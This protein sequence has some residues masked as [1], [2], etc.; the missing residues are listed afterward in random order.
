MK[1]VFAVCL[2]SALAVGCLSIFS[3]C[4]PD[5]IPDGFGEWEGNYVYKGNVRSKT[6]GEDGERLVTEVVLDGVV[7]DA[8]RC[9]DYEF[10][11]DDIYL[12]LGLA[13]KQDEEI[14]GESVR[15][16]T[17][18]ALVRYNVKDKMRETV[19]SGEVR[20]FQN[21][22][23][24]TEN[25]IV[26][27]GR[28]LDREGN[29]L[30]EDCSYYSKYDEIGEYLYR[31]ENGTLFYRTWENEEETAFAT[32]SENVSLT[33]INRGN[34]EGFLMKESRQ[35]NGGSENRLSYYDLKSGETTKLLSLENGSYFSFIGNDDGRY[36]MK[37]QEERVS[38]TKKNP[39][40]IFESATNESVSLQLNCELYEIKYEE[41]GAKLEKLYVFPADK[42]FAGGWKFYEGKAYFISEW[43]ESASGC[44]GGGVKHKYCCMELGKWSMREVKREE[45][46]EVGEKVFLNRMASF[47]VSCGGY[48]YWFRYGNVPVLWG[49]SYWYS[50]QRTDRATGKTEAMQY[51][52][53]VPEEKEKYCE[54]M[55]YDCDGYDYDE[56]D[57]DDDVRKWIVREY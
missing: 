13:E 1:K 26:A 21:I 52:G 19:I 28:K 20:E 48:D 10:F 24:V 31:K 5:Y 27:E 54:E 55:W 16:E 43:A 33:Y 39:S 47:S 45:Y 57:V 56:Y 25:F 38:Y 53:N 14:S 7:Y 36:L 30:E 46:N 35:A 32:V 44:K 11:G 23:K 34:A 37:C 22:R 42:D 17:A 29:I 49:N 41:G 51:W 40:R 18:S 12:C 3:G 15:G 8:T 4:K 9:T 6:T 2:A 50:L